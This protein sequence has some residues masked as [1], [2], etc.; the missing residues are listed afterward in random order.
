MKWI[1]I[2]IVLVVAASASGCVDKNQAETTGQTPAQ[3][4]VSPGEPGEAAVTPGAVVTPVI[5]TPSAG[6]PAVSPAPDDLFGT[7]SNL[8]AIDTTFND[9]NMEISLLDTI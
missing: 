1:Y 8:S 2:L 6:S 5:A 7:E 4:S 3:T 9:M